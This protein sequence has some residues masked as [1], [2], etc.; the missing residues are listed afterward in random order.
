MDQKL[1]YSTDNGSNICSESSPC[2][3]DVFHTVIFF[4]CFGQK[5]NES[6]NL[7]VFSSWFLATCQLLNRTLNK[8]KQYFVR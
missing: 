7:F 3:T 4:Q 8:S 2:L 5:K 1:I 6:G